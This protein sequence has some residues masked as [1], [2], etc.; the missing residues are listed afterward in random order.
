MTLP[1]FP[2]EGNRRVSGWERRGRFIAGKGGAMNTPDYLKV[3]VEDIHSTVVATI[4]KDG[5]PVTRC[6]DMM[7][8]DEEGIYFL[9]SR[10]KES[11]AQLM[12]QEYLSL[13]A[14]KDGRCVSL[15][16]RASNIGKRK[17]DEIFEKNAYMEALY[18]GGARTVLEVFR[19]HDAKGNYFDIS[20]PSNVTRG[21]FVLP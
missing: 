10:E 19:I 18:P 11:Y 13:S 2:N 1:G 17:L 6:I 14:V 12:E 15:A 4:G 8:Y 16:G 21:T 7:L 9:T 3:I 5:H 20:D